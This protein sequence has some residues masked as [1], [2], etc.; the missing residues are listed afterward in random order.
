MMLI[1]R[2]FPYF[3]TLDE[4]REYRRW[5]VEIHTHDDNEIGIAKGLIEKADRYI[6]KEERRIAAKGN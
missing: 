6:A 4:M 3:G 2:D 1:C 5:V